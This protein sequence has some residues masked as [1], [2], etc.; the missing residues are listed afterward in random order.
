MVFYKRWLSEKPKG[1]IELP[2]THQH[3]VDVS[4]SYDIFTTDALESVYRLM[5]GDYWSPNGEA[6]PMMERRQLRHTSMMEGDV[7]YLDGNYHMVVG[8]GFE[9]MPF[10]DDGPVIERYWNRARE[11]CEEWRYIGAKVE[12]SLPKGWRIKYQ[13]QMLG[14]ANLDRELMIRFG[15]TEEQARHVNNTSTQL[16]AFEAGPSE[17]VWTATWPE[18]D[19]DAYANLWQ[20]NPTFGDGEMIL[21]LQRYD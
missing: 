16:T 17:I 7:V 19:P 20:W 6:M 1:H 15:L 14:K 18:P 11:V 2:M 13:Q 4:V 21:R 3:L 9:E 10:T 5:Q 12:A 8:F